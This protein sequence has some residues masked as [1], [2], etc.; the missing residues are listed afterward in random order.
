MQSCNVKVS[1]CYDKESSSNKELSYYNYNT[2]KAVKAVHMHQRFLTFVLN[3]SSTLTKYYHFTLLHKYSNDS[4]R[5]LNC[6]RKTN[7]IKNNDS[8]KYWN[9]FK[10]FINISQ[11]LKLHRMLS[12]TLENVINMNLCKSRF[13]NQAFESSSP[14][15]N[16]ALI[17]MKFSLQ[18]CKQQIARM[19]FFQVFSIVVK[20]EQLYI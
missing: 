18:N 17:K 6:F 2:N 10:R 16:I 11:N 20:D 7:R 19:I 9:T 13:R 3:L 14:I 8:I 15:I 4:E 1:V 12:M 5:A